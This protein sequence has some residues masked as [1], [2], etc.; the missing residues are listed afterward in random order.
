MAA[1][2]IIE[3]EPVLAHQLAVALRSGG[4]EVRTAGNG[5]Q[6]LV[7]AEAATPDLVLL[8][9]RLPDRSGLDLI[10]ALKAIDASVPIV[11]MTAYGSVRDAVEAIRR[12]AADYLNKPLDVSELGLLI[13]RLLSQQ[14][15]DRELTYLRG[16]DARDPEEAI[17]AHPRL[18]D[19]FVQVQR[20]CDAGLPAGRRPSILLTGET[21]TGKG[22]T[23]RAIHD[24][25]GGGPFIE[26]NCFGMPASWIESELFGRERGADTRASQ[27]GLFEAGEG[28]TVFLDEI[29]DLDLDLQAKFLRL[30]E[31]KRVERIGSDRVRE[32]NVHVLASTRHDLDAAVA[33]G[34]FRPDLLHR[35]RVLSFEIPPLRERPE[36]LGLLARHFAREIGKQYGGRPRQISLEAEK[37]LAGYDWPGNVRE[38][39]NLIERAALVSPD[40]MLGVEV[41]S[42][43]LEP[44]PRPSAPG[45][46][47]LPEEGLR[48]EDVERDLLRQALVRAKGNRTR[49]SLLLGVSRDTLRY[50]ISK[51]GLDED[52]ER[53]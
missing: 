32:V 49:A 1:V 7:E 19:V 13:E 48:L 43:L 35:L 10:P 11:L 9:L 39:R 2:L 6:G 30:I 21:G 25:L 37:L 20:L 12:G 27:P 42:T 14:R 26:V 36:D 23:A 45:Q 51:W 24:L 16:R 17:S 18:L 3:D 5:A 8:D 47:L 46:V 41:L 4:H 29:G 33:E 38:L 53:P 22:V 50:R 52:A 34:R 40:E 31:E 15:R 28:G 44:A